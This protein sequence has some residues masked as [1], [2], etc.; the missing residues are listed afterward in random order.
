MNL[1]KKNFSFFPNSF[2]IKYY[3]N[4][5]EES[6]NSFKSLMILNIKNRKQNKTPLFV[7]RRK[8]ALDSYLNIKQKSEKNNNYNLLYRNHIAN[9]NNTITSVNNYSKNLN[10][11][12]KIKKE[13]IKKNKKK[14]FEKK[15]LLIE[16][17]SKSSEKK[18]HYFNKFFNQNISVKKININ[19]INKSFNNNNNIKNKLKPNTKIFNINDKNIEKKNLNINNFKIEYIQNIQYNKSVK[20]INFNKELTFKKDEFLNEI[21]IDENTIN[22]RKNELNKFINFTNKF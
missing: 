8:E 21:Q 10:I 16:K 13:E 7:K 3:K 12:S 2:M 18:S 11:I 1:N 15:M 5:N 20:K 17:K 4:S 22:K 6:K 19:N 9:T 14:E